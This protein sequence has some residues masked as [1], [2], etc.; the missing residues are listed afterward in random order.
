MKLELERI[1]YRA[2]DK[3]I[4]LVRPSDQM[5]VQPKITSV[6]ANQNIIWGDD[7]LMRW[8]TNNTCLEAAAHGNYTYGK[9]EPRSR[10]TDGF[11]AF[12][13]AMSIED[14]IPQY[15]NIQFFAPICI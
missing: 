3:D 2:A 6:F 8:F 7:P 10:K 11:M 1:G 4:K 14:A 9:I 13:A 5:L 12:V 15:N